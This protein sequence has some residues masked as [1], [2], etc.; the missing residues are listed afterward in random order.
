MSTHAAELFARIIIETEPY[1][2]DLVFVGGWVHAHLRQSGHATRRIGN[3]TAA[4]ASVVAH[5][6]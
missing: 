1:H 2:R 3:V 6:G 5:T 4:S